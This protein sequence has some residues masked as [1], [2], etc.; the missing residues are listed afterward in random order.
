MSVQAITHKHGYRGDVPVTN[1][2]ELGQGNIVM[3]IRSGN[4][5]INFCDDHCVSRNAAKEILLDYHKA[6]WAIIQS[7]S[8]PS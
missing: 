3:T 7:L 1:R 6:G 8:K 2:K 4:T 5:V